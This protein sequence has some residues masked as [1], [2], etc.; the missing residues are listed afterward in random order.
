MKPMIRHSAPIVLAVCALAS[1]AHA[2]VATKPALT[3]DGAQKILAAAESEARK[4]NFPA[5]IAVVDDGGNLL[6]LARLDGIQPASAM[7]AYGKAHTSALFRRPTSVFEDVIRNGR[8]AMVALSDFTPL[9]GGVPI[10]YDGQ[11]IGA[12]GVSGANPM[13]DEHIAKTAADA[14]TA[15]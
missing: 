13:I 1:H 12:V 8:T 9:Q 7:V 2:Q 14:V 10:T 3:H 11:V 15:K 6:A 5:A 4:Q